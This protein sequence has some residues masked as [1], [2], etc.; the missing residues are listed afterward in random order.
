MPLM[1][2]PAKRMEV[3]AMAFRASALPRSSLG[4]VLAT[5]AC[6]VGWTKA[7]AMPETSM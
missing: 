6:R 7:K 3:T 5:N 1:A 2:A 4:T